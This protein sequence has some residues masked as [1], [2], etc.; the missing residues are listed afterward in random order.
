[1]SSPP[2]H[3]SNSPSP[4]A[5][6]GGS[7]TGDRQSRTSQGPP[8][9]DRALLWLRRGDRLFVGVLAGAALILMGVHWG[10]LSGWGSKPID[11]E[12]L[13]QA[14]YQYEIDINRA[15]WVE[16]AQFNGVGET[17]AKRIVADR[18]ANGDFDSVEDLLRVK[19]IGRQK[20]T[21]MRRHLRVE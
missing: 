1:M 8:D 16:W 5:G 13:P 12:H 2:D 3:T 7:P 6:T 15:T 10:R 20:F 18:E 21:G 17:L 19:G 11:I 14:A 4:I 9:S